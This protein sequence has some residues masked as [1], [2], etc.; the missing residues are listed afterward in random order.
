MERMCNGTVWA[1][2]VDLCTKETLNLLLTAASVR[3][4]YFSYCYRKV[5]SRNVR[6]SVI[7]SVLFQD[8][9]Q[10]IGATTEGAILIFES[11]K[12]GTSTTN[13]YGDVMA[14]VSIFTSMS[15]ASGRVTLTDSLL[16]VSI[17]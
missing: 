16:P 11:L 14:T 9:E 8:F 13:S 12:N 15:L 5:I 2:P 17:F 1:D 10:G 6:K 4:I 7:F 3:Q